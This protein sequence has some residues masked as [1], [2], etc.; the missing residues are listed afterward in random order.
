[1]G[2]WG[3]LCRASFLASAAGER[4]I[5]RASLVGA[6]GQRPG[7]REPACHWAQSMR[8]PERVRCVRTGSCGCF[9]GDLAG[10]WAVSQK[11]CEWFCEWTGLCPIRAG[12]RVMSSHFIVASI[13]GTEG[14]CPGTLC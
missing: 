1:M 3:A 5:T 10:L 4:G 6:R 13:S 2:F 14:L 12:L 11:D 7:G 8:F 9:R